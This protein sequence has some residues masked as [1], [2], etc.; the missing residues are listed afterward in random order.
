MSQVIDG[1][2]LK[3]KFLDLKTVKLSGIKFVIKRINPLLDLP[4]NKIPTCFTDFISARKTTEVPKLSQKELEALYDLMS[5][6]IKAGVY[7]PKLLPVDKE[8]P[9]KEKGL[10]IKD[11]FLDE[12]L[13]YQLYIEIMAHACFRF[14]TVG[15]I[16]FSKGIKRWLSTIWPRSIVGLPS[17]SYSP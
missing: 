8:N 12:M 1:E 13:A 3:S 14:S 2:K 9:Y 5:Y 6:V 10:T 15:K 16:F 4:S 17:K 11:I 7:S